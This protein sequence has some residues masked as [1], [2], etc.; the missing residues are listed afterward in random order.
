MRQNSNVQWKKFLKEY[1][2]IINKT[3]IPFEYFD[4]HTIWIDFLLHGF[5]DH[6]PDLIKFTI[7]N[8]N[9]NE[10]KYFKLLVQKYFEFG[11]EYFNPM[12][13]RTNS[14]L[15]ELKRILKK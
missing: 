12:A 14:E 7:D 4:Q 3:G 15:I 6:Q 8:L 11:F 2:N 1:S 9:V 5:I 13:L 10:Y